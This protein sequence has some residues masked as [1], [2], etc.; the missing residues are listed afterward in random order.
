MLVGVRDHIELWDRA[1]W[2]EYVASQQSQY[3]DLAER[4]FANTPKN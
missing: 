2:D 1:R 4:A 3:D